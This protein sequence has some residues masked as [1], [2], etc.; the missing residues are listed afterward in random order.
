MTARV[1]RR[2]AALW[3]AGAALFFAPLAAGKVHYAGDLLYSFHPW[4]TYAAQSIQSGRLPF[5]NPYSACGE[6]MLA[7]P[8]LMAFHP[9][10]L[11]FWLF[12]FGTAWKLFLPATSA[13]T[14]AAACLLARRWAKGGSLVLP[15]ALALTWGASV[16]VMWEFP[17]ATATWPF[18]LFAALAAGTGAWRLTAF[19]TALLVLGGYTPYAVYG[20]LWA[21]GHAAWLVLSAR[22]AADRRARLQLSAGWAA[23]AGLGLALAL[24]QLLPGWEA[25][26]ESLRSTMSSDE[27]RSFLLTPVFLVKFL[28]P[29]VFDKVSLAFRP[30]VFGTEF[31]PVQRNWLNAFY[32]GAPALLLGL[33]SLAAVR[34]RTAF[35]AVS[36]AAALLMASGAEPLFSAALASVP[37]L[38]YMS[39]FSNF[40]VLAVLSLGLLAAVA[41][42][43]PDR[44]TRAFRAF[45]AAALALCVAIA[46]SPA[47]RR[48]LLDALLGLPS[49][50]PTQDRWVARAAAAAGAGVVLTGAAFTAPARWKAWALCAVALSQLW[51]FGRDLNPTADADFFRRP[52]PLARRWQEAP[53]R[54]AVHPQALQRQK[55]MAGNTLEEGYQ[56]LRQALYPNVGLPFRVRSAWAY[57]VFPLA[58]FAAFRRELAREDLPRLLDAVGADGVL[59]TEPLGAPFLLIAR[60]A[61]ALLYDHAGAPPIVRT[62]RRRSVHPE[63]AERLRYLSDGWDPRTEVVLEQEADSR[64]G[65]GPGT[66]A[67]AD[68]AEA[69]GRVEASGEGSGWLVYGGAH[70]P[71]WRVYVD[72][73]RSEL[74]RADH[75]FMAGAV[76]EGRWKA[77]FFYV[78]G[79]FLWG[80]AGTL[81]ALAAVLWAEWTR[82]RKKRKTA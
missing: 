61:N 62:V 76:P 7:N 36:G 55:P 73:R 44:G 43:G 79:R 52:L 65:A 18:V 47:A 56:S 15:A 41:E 80:L 13:L 51:L 60:S 58:R 46:L 8:Q 21:G 53:R 31:W 72:G 6:P 12:P 34:R 19:G 45:W 57:E 20:L 54:F 48:T 40:T 29:D 27:T 35:L 25:A 16:T 63:S 1:W 68:W 64:E 67:T 3:A 28:I 30:G 71:G 23:A 32:V 70:Y 22:G 82:A 33:T 17:G 5:W 50:S 74:L 4:L 66:A 75:A 39:H 77:V 26:R 49:L 2:A 11:L 24:L 38:R 81:A 37:G 69:E 42:E 78:P 10:G 9:F 14:F 59:A